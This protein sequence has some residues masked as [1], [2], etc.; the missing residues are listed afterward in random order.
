MFSC[1]TASVPTPLLSL[2]DFLTLGSWYSTRIFIPEMATNMIST[3][4][5]DYNP[6]AEGVHKLVLTTNSVRNTTFASPDDRY[7][8]EVCTWFWH[9]NVTK[10]NIHE[11]DTKLMRTVA[12]IEK[13]TA[14]RFRVRFKNGEQEFG[15]WISDID[16]L[17]P[18]SDGVWVHVFIQNAIFAQLDVWYEPNSGGVFYDTEGVGYRWK[19]HNRNL[20]VCKANAPAWVTDADRFMYSW[21]EWTTRRKPLW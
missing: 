8:Y 20:Q 6:D 1:H 4:I 15:N 12:E 11:H 9:R 2:L 14:G 19:T 7:Y 17:K 18:D 13:L 10:I 5:P 3:N 21:W 16:F